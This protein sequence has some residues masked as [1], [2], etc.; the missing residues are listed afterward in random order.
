MH[1]DNVLYLYSWLVGQFDQPPAH[2]ET[3]EPHEREKLCP[4]DMQSLS[5]YKNKTKQ[6]KD[7]VRA[8]ENPAAIIVFDGHTFEENIST[9]D[10]EIFYPV[11][12]EKSLPIS[13]KLLLLRSSG[14]AST[15]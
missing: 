15:T 14:T 2:T 10:G 12:K 5:S 3:H 13:K 7:P 8:S 9:R 4:P 1:S 6:N 11:A